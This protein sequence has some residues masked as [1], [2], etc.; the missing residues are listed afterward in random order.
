MLPVGWIRKAVAARAA[1]GPRVP[2]A[3]R[4]QAAPLSMPWHVRTLILPLADEPGLLF[5]NLITGA[6]RIA[7]FDDEPADHDHH[8]VV[9]VKRGDDHRAGTLTFAAGDLTADAPDLC[10]ASSGW[11][12]RI[13]GSW[14]QYHHELSVPP[15]DLRLDLVTTCEEPLH[16][17]SQTHPL[18]SHYSAF[19]R[20]AGKLTIGASSGSISGWTSLEH[21]C[22]GNLRRLPGKPSLPASMFHY[23]LGALDSGELFAL[24]TFA[25]MGVEF[26]HRGVLIAADGSRLPIDHWELRDVAQESIEDRC[27]GTMEVPA[28]LHL[29]GRSEQLELDY[30]AEAICPTLAG[31]GRL[32]SGAA[33]LRGTLGRAGEEPEEVTGSAYVEHLYPRGSPSLPR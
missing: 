23:Q 11:T 27:G 12:Y 5:L 20:A 21:G 29:T 26:F 2:D 30:D 19:G 32:T 8:L 22:G 18:Y 9:L 16:W 13:A 6:T 31:R 14:P 4:E 1:S 3:R 28:A 15:W 33:S 7:G 24:G 25:S 10:V 17:W